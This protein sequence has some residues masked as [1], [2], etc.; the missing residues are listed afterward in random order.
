MSSTIQGHRLSLEQS[1]RKARE[2]E[3]L[4]NEGTDLIEV[5]R[6]L[7]ISEAIWNRWRARNAGM[8]GEEIK[9]LKEF[10]HK[11]GRLK[12]PVAE[13]V[14]DNAVHGPGPGDSDRDSSTLAVLH[15]GRK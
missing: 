4:L 12:N 7:E 10:E 11:N 15:P 2:S 8:T 1:L 14:L 3:R 6:N 9:R 5:L 13:Q